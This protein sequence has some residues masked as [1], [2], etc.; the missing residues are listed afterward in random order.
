MH[1]LY[2]YLID[3]AD[4]AYI[5]PFVMVA[6]GFGIILWIVAVFAMK[7]ERALVKG[8]LHASDQAHQRVVGDMMHL[9][10]M[11]FFCGSICLG[12]AAWAWLAGLS[13]RDYAI[14]RA[15]HVVNSEFRPFVMVASG[16][17]ISLWIVAVLTMIR[18]NALVKGGPDA[19]D[20][21]SQRAVGDMRHLRDDS[22]VAPGFYFGGICL[23]LAAWAWFAGLST[24]YNAID[25]A[26]Y[27]M[28]PDFRLQGVVLQGPR[29]QIDG[30]MIPGDA[31]FTYANQPTF[32]EGMTIPPTE[33]SF[34]IPSTEAVRIMRQMRAMG[35]TVPEPTGT[36][37]VQVASLISSPR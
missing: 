7:R 25:H 27:V 9:R 23:A 11:C 31:V 18:E 20:P 32:I 1:P 16:L 28:N 37:G 17:G 30:M 36:D 22:I 35:M 24:R 4:V 33:V 21:G 3:T 2:Q 29:I 6:S 14:D 10:C 13:T 12:L 26:Q 15:Q 5:I 34:R 8:A 19:S